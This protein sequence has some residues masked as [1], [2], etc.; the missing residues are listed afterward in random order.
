MYRVCG[1][2]LGPII[3][4]QL[5]ADKRFHMRLSV[6]KMHAFAVLNINGHTTACLRF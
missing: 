5:A 1:L 6:E 3:G 4:L 2:R